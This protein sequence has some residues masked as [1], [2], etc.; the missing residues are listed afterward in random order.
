[1]T[2]AEIEAETDGES[3]TAAEEAGGEK[4]N[5]SGGESVEGE[6]PSAAIC[7]D[8]ASSALTVDGTGDVGSVGSVIR[9]LRVGVS[10]SRA[11]AAYTVKMHGDGQGVVKQK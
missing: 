1:M 3:E 11:D 6:E 5:E 10:S 9:T 4:E 8:V 2:E 7:D